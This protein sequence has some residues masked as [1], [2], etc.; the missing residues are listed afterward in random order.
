MKSDS[1]EN[2]RP[3]EPMTLKDLTPQVAAL[4]CY[5]GGWIS[6]IVFLVLEQKNRF[7][8][9]HALQS[10]I[11]FGI[12]TLVATVFGNLPVVGRF[13][14]TI[15][16]ITAFILWIILMVKA[17]SGEYFKLPLSG[18][19]AER[20]TNESMGQRPQ[21]GPQPGPADNTPPSEPPAPAVAPAVAYTSAGVSKAAAF[22][23]RYYS[24]RERN[25][26]ITASAFAIAWNI[27]LLIFFNFYNRYIAWYEPV[28]SGGETTWQVHTLITPD[29]NSWLPILT[30]A[31]VLG[32]ISHA[33]MI[34]IDKYI[35]RQALQI[36]LDIFSVIV[37][38]SLLSIFPF[39]F[40]SL[41]GSDAAHWVT[42][43]VTFILIVL[44]VGFGI[45]ALVRFIQLIVNVAEGKY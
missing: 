15:I 16:G 34:A 11:V 33:I 13:F 40:S 1:T 5:V 44:A 23:D 25:G 24:D 20:L 4:L 3:G 22:R 8:R 31:L 21:P 35:L 37:V 7:V 28:T 18:D 30:A 2:N 26:R 41:P 29:F 10:I 38:V 42:I 39:D 45:G 36:F 27:A 43:G 17:L 9:F 14:G 19:L 6:G 12:I 32:I